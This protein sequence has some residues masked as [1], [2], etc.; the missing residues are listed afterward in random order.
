MSDVMQLRLTVSGASQAELELPAR[1]ANAGDAARVTRLPST[2][3]DQATGRRR[4]EVVVDGWRFEVA[5][6]SAERAA[7]RRR[8]QKVAAAG[9]SQGSLSLRAQIPGRVTRVW[10]G[11]GALVE[12]GERLLAIEA[13]K[14]ENEIRAPRAGIVEALALEE[15]HLVELNQELLTIAPPAALDS[16]QS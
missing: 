6:E 10:V 4:F 14:M 12:Q 16:S 11:E 1:K 9:L 8:A 2:A 5:A 3:D 15:G 7:L 13:M